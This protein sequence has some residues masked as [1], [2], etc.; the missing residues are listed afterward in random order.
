MPETTASVSSFITSR[1]GFLALEMIED[2]ARSLAGK[3][4]ALQK[5]LR[6]ES[7]PVT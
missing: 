4:E 7:E 2:M 6:S 3:P 5:H 1:G